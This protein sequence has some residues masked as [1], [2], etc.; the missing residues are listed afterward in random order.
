MPEAAAIIDVRSQRQE[1]KVLAIH[2][3]LQI[4]HAWK[5]GPR[6]LLLI[7]RA[8]GFLRIEQVAQTSL[9]TW[10]V[11]IATRADAH[12]RPCRLRRRAFADALGRRIF[13]RAASLTPAAVVVLA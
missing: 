4:E 5:A 10:S 7:P 3:V 13:V 2:V 12:H 1:R 8:V 9:N 6:D 11:Q